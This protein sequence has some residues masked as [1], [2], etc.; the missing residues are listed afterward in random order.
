[1]NEHAKQGATP[2]PVHLVAGPLGVG[3][4]TAILSY[5]ERHAG[6]E[7]VAVLVNDFGPVGMDGAI[8]RGAIGRVVGDQMKVLTIPGGC[9]C[10]ASADALAV[11]SSAAALMAASAPAQV[12][13]PEVHG[14][15]LAVAREILEALGATL[16]LDS[17]P[18]KGTRAT[19]RISVPE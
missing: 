10:C 16:K 7:H 12:V 17:E 4:T 9:L 18:G 15:G 5:V 1:M 13:G 3:K 8:M 14:V 19:I 11:A 6:R 2:L